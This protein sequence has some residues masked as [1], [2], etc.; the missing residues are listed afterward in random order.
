MQEFLELVFERLELDWHNYVDIDPR[1][2]RPSEVDMLI[3]DSSKA[4]RVGWQPKV[5][6]RNWSR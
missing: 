6:F 5:S 4:A 1:H 2:L 3:G